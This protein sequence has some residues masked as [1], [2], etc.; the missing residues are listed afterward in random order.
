MKQSIAFTRIYY[1][2]YAHNIL[3]RVLVTIDGVWICE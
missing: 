1:I 3:P 2:L